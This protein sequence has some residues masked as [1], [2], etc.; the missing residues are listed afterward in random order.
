[1]IT[2]N[3]LVARAMSRDISSSDIGSMCKI[4]IRNEYRMN[5]MGDFK[6][7]YHEPSNMLLFLNK[8]LVIKL[9]NDLYNESFILPSKQELSFSL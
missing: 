9:I 6:S 8:Q 2:L 3:K 5:T 4:F 1:M 7:I